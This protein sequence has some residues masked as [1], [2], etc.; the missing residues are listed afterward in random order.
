MLDVKWMPVQPTAR[1]RRDSCAC[2][3]GLCVLQ[4]ATLQLSST[5]PEVPTWQPPLPAAAVGLVATVKV[6][7]APS[8]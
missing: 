2:N 7:I 6:W 4:R 1:S 3:A 8:I 5:N